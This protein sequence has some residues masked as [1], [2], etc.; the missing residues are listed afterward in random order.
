MFNF[1]IEDFHLPTEL[2]MIR[3]GQFMCYDIFLHKSFK[4]SI[5]EMIVIVA[6]YDSKGS[7]ARENVLFYELD[8]NLVVI[9]LARNGFYPF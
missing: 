1:S 2:R 3:C 5:V 9:R 7:K 4:S 8:N 6:N